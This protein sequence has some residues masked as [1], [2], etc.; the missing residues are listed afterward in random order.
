MER[1]AET[2]MQELLPVVAALAE[3][4]TGGESTS[5]TYEKAQE[6]MGAVLYCIR[7]YEEECTFDPALM[8]EE[9][10]PVSDAYQKGYDLVIRKVRKM[11]AFYNRLAGNFCSYDCR[12]YEEVLSKGLP[13]FFRRYDPKFAPQKTI[14]T[15]DYPTL[16]PMG[17]L[18]GIDAIEQYLSC[19]ALEQKFLGAFEEAYVRRVLSAYDW[20]YREQFFNLCGIFLEYV[21]VCTLMGRPFSDPVT[22]EHLER[23]EMRKNGRTK[24]EIQE[25]LERILKRLVEERYRGNE[26]LYE[27]LCGAV[28]EIAVRIRESGSRAYVW[29]E[30]S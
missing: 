14:L 15:L 19:L 27:Y 6:L 17:P 29:M 4:Y 9:G 10:V 13:E 26:L 1:R 18:T 20:N 2:K 23:L 5:V 3:K 8:T 16:T 24:E 12:N 7:E 11:R 25:E 22:A 30:R 21:L 28:P